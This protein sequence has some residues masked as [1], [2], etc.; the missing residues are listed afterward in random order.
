ML[1]AINGGV[2]DRLP[3]TGHFVMPW[4]LDK[5]MNG[6]TVEDFYDAC[7][8]DPIA[9][10][11]FHRPDESRGEYY[12]PLQKEIG[13]L[14]SRRICTDQWQI[15]TEPLAGREYPATAFTFAT[16]GGTLRM[17]LEFDEYSAWVTE[18]PVKKKD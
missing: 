15:H 6:I 17:V 18:Y 7:G 5:Y 3:V 9:Y 13:F 1:T 10:P 2:P 8:W 12:D 11:T 14:E 16:P 4:Y